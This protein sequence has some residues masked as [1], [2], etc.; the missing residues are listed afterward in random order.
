MFIYSLGICVIAWAGLARINAS[1]QEVIQIVCC[2]F[3]EVRHPDLRCHSPELP[4][5]WPLGLPA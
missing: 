3:T 1:V 2:S 5:I 4:F